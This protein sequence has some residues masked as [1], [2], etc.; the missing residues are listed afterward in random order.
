MPTVGPLVG[1]SLLCQKY[2][3]LKFYN[4]TDFTII[5]ERLRFL[6][7]SLSNLTSDYDIRYLEYIKNIIFQITYSK[8]WQSDLCEIEFIRSIDKPSLVTWIICCYIY[9]FCNIL[10]LQVVELCVPWLPYILPTMCFC[11]YLGPCQCPS[12]TSWLVGSVVFSLCPF[13]FPGIYNPLLV[14]VL[15]WFSLWLS[16]LASSCPVFSQWVSSLYG[17]VVASLIIFKLT[18]CLSVSFQNSYS[19]FKMILIF[20]SFL[21]MF[22]S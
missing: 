21:S 22:F 20:Y 17:S 12:L 14:L 3:A 15:Q 8:V 19:Y 11:Y 2:H 4:L 16:V 7:L 9:S 10:L 13:L 5:F 1:R 6:N 18:S